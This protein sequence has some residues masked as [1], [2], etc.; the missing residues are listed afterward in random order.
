MGP[1]RRFGAPSGATRRFR[2]PTWSPPWRKGI[3]A[4]PA[5]D[6]VA[7]GAGAAVPLATVL[8]G[9]LASVG[10]LQT[11]MAVGELARRWNEVVGD[12]LRLETAPSSLK[13]GVLTIR[14]SSSGWAMQLR[15]L[16]ETLARNAN[17]V[18][19]RA[20]VT[21]VRVVVDPRLL[22]GREGHDNGPK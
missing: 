10:S 18:V 20:A 8:D 19:G 11:G 16:A 5:E 9:L 17:D 14:A 15:F 4:T 3:P 22:E 13:D 12:P 7:P 1:R 6:P 2:T 21:Q